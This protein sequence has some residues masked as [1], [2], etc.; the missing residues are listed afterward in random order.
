MDKFRTRISQNQLHHIS[1]AKILSKFCLHKFSRKL[2]PNCGK[3]VLSFKFNAFCP[4]ILNQHCT[5]KMYNTQNMQAKCATSKIYTSKLCASKLR[6]SIILFGSC[7]LFKQN[8]AVHCE[9]ALW[10]GCIW[11]A[12][13][14]LI[15]SSFKQAAV[16]MS[17]SHASATQKP[18][19][20]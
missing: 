16:A 7:M 2:N 19:D 10:F 13:V 18:G 4:V 20:G 12:R 17:W 5:S 11:R 1:S 15:D 6:T 3:C 9:E 14:A 8:G